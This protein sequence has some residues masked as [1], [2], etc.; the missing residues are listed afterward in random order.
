MSHPWWGE[1]DRKTGLG[2]D[3]RT[4]MEWP[5]PGR[6]WAS[7]WDRLTGPPLS[8]GVRSGAAS[9]GQ[10]GYK[11]NSGPGCHPMPGQP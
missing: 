4:E 10:F 3:G 9:A 2:W 11:K 8:A 7:G 1:G 6:V 5:G